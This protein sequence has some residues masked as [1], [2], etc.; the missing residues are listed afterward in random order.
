M[1]TERRY[2]AR[3]R[4]R[5]SPK[6]FNLKVCISW[7]ISHQVASSLASAGTCMSGLND[8]TQASVQAGGWRA[9]ST[10]PSGTAGSILTSPP[11]LVCNTGRAQRVAGDQAGWALSGP[12]TASCSCGLCQPVL[13]WADGGEAAQGE[14]QNSRLLCSRPSGPCSVTVANEYLFCTMYQAP[15]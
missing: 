4:V 10:G 13:A 1:L 15:C 6:H 11:G 3:P 7:P 2:T 12:N 8:T 9:K 14:T 5:R